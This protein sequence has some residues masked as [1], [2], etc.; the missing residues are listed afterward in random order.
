M[1]SIDKLRIIQSAAQHALVVSNPDYDSLDTYEQERFRVLKS[2]EEA[3]CVRRVL[4]EALLGIQCDEMQV[5]DI[6]DD[7]HPKH[8]KMLNWALLLTQGIGEDFIDL[9]EWIADEKSLLDF[10]TLYE[11]DY[12]H[13]LYQEEARRQDFEDYQGSEYFGLMYACWVRLF[14]N[15]QFYYGTLNSLANYIIDEIETLVDDRIESLIP[16]SYE[17]GDEHGKSEEDGV[18]WD[19]K[20][21]ADGKESQ[22]EELQR[23]WL[24]YQDNRILEL[25]AR[26]S[27]YEPAVYV[28]DHPID[29]DPNKVFIFTNARTLQ[30]IRWRTFLLDCN[31]F[32][33]D[34]SMVQAILDEEMATASEFI[35]EQYQDIIDNFDPTVLPLK[36]KPKIII[37]SRALDDM[38]RL[39]EDDD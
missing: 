27:R 25:Q 15:G 37:S 38:K 21:V 11:Y 18:I 2:S 10:D 34:Y 1:I 23:R 5:D 24:Q 36:K 6:W 8:S 4:L 3:R 17:H 20:L 12:H 13:F 33:K 35:D 29:D 19:V 9:N 39:S 31:A 22:L 16:H 28:H 14:I 30:D 26:F 32:Q 7:V